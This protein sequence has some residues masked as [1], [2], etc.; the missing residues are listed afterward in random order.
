MIDILASYPETEDDRAATAQLHLPRLLRAWQDGDLGERDTLYIMLCRPG[1]L[2]RSPEA[3]THLED[4]GQAM[5]ADAGMGVA[6]QLVLTDTQEG[7]ERFVALRWRQAP[8]GVG[9][10]GAT[11]LAADLSSP[12]GMMR[13]WQATAGTEVGQPIAASS[14]TVPWLR[15]YGR[16]SSTMMRPDTPVSLRSLRRLG[17]PWP[18][19]CSRLPVSRSSCGQTD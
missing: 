14:S 5:A 10:A 8:P 1:E 15:S 7:A 12:A 4:Q 13:A 18:R 6:V 9:G 16:S 19:R 2:A 3:A 11:P 17:G